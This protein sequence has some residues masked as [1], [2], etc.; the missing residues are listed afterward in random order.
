[1]KNSSITLAKRSCEPERAEPTPVARA[2]VKVIALYQRLTAGRV[3]A[4]RFY[5]SCSSYALEAVQLH[6]AVRGGALALRRLSRCRPLGPHGV[7]LVPQPPQTRSTQ[8]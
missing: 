7:D 3:S 6:G 5:P 8:R 2:L 4:C 1:M